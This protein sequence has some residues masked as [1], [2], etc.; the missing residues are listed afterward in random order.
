[1]EKSN[2]SNMVSDNETTLEKIIAQSLE[3]E[4]VSQ[5]TVD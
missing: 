2:L 4:I 1:M 3:K 5:T